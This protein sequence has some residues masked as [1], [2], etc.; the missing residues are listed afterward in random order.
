MIGRVVHS[1]VQ[2]I[3]NK[4][5]DV[6]TQPPSRCRLGRW[7]NEVEGARRV[8]GSGNGSQVLYEGDKARA[9]GDDIGENP[10]FAFLRDLVA[11]LA[12]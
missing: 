1:L 4:I 11:S 7:R 3:A 10:S 9:V 2:D 6:K 8:G 12:D 5:Q